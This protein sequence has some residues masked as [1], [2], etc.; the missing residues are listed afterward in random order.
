MG[1]A[2]I[3]NFAFGVPH[4]RGRRLSSQPPR[5]GSAPARPLTNYIRCSKR[6]SCRCEVGELYVYDAALR[7]GAHLGLAPTFVYLHAGTRLGARALGLGQGRA[8][9]EMHEL[10]LP[11]QALSPDEVESFL[12]IYKAF[13]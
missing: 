3:T 5:Q 10:P 2:T 12:C 4:G 7:L 13:L 9:L 11:L 6:S 1:V 8:Y